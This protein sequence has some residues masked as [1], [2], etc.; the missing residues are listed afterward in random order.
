M[1]NALLMSSSR[2]G[3][4]GY[5]EHAAPQLN[6]VLEGTSRKVLFVPYAAV[7]FSYD[8][9]E[10]LAAPPFTAVD[11]ELTSIHRFDDPVAAVRAADVIAIGGGNSF[12]LLNRLYGAELVREIRTQVTERGTTYIGWSAGT[13]VATPTI[14]TTNDMPIVEPPSLSAI[15]L[16][17]FQINP[18]FIS[19]KPAGHNGESREERLA[20]FTAINPGEE[21]LAIVEGTALHVTG[22]RGTILSNAALDSAGSHSADGLVFANAAEPRTIAAGESFELSEISG[23]VI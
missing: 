10:D 7:S 8:T 6:T 18:H 2:M 19:G 23:P 15:G 21:V 20:E 12:A 4:L 3:S 17:P 16:V 11:A 9:Y 13:N 14:R 22:S 5:L 1:T